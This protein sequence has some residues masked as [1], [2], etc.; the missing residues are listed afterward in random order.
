M[1]ISEKNVQCLNIELYHAIVS[2]TN[3]KI[4]NHNIRNCKKWNGIMRN[5]II[6]YHKINC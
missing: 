6:T 4:K 2:K 3:L 5:F 1:Y